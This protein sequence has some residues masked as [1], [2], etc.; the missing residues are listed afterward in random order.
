MADA[1]SL[2]RHDP[3]GTP[4]GL[5]R[6]RGR[7]RCAGLEPFDVEV[8]M[9]RRGRRGALAPDRVPAARAAGRVGAV[10]RAADRRH[11]PAQDG[12]RAARTAPPPG[13]GGGGHGPGLLGMGPRGRPG[14]LVGAQQGALRP[15]GRTTGEPERYLELVHPEDVEAV[16]AAFLAAR[17]QPDGRRLF[18]SSIGWSRRPASSAGSWRTA[19]SPP[20]PTGEARLVVGTSLDITERKAAEERRALL[21]GE[22]AHRAKNGIAVLMAIVSQTARGQETRRGLPGADH[23]PPAGHG[24]FA[25]P[26][27]GV[28]RRGRWRWPR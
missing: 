27:D 22:L 8:A 11:R 20:T 28:G 4:R 19:G 18:A 25:G 2:L 5:R 13:S 15:G 10:G 3:A 1:A 14:E 16:R 24:Q 7:R 12:R 23:G 9:R 26:G 6:G 21:M 17:D